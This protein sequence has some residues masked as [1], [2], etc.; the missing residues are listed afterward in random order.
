[1]LIVGVTAVALWVSAAWGLALLH[2]PFSVLST[3]GE[4]EAAIIRRVMPHHLVRPE[5]VKPWPEGE[6]RTPWLL[7]ETK[8]R[9]AIIGVGWISAVVL[10]WKVGKRRA[11]HAVHGSL[12]SSAP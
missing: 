6:L 9:M 3:P 1:V 5:W 11:N 7:A 12:A 10:F 4:S 2:W 8:V